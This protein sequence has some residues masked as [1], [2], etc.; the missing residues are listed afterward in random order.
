MVVQAFVN[1]NPQFPS[2]FRSSESIVENYDQN[3][4]REK[5][6]GHNSQWEA[7][8]TTRDTK[9]KPGFLP[10]LFFLVNGESCNTTEFL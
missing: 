8:E 10:V 5:S 9:I 7:E 4:E 3:K 1:L 2:G 6:T